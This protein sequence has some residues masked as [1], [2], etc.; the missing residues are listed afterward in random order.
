MEHKK[1]CDG[2]KLVMFDDTQQGMTAAHLA[3]AHAHTE[4]LVE[5][6]AAFMASAGDGASEPEEESAV[7]AHRVAPAVCLVQPRCKR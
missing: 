6:H 3:A 4:C 7:R 1:Y 2:Q 5:L